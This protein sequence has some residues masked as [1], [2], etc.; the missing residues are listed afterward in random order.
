MGEGRSGGF[1]RPTFFAI[2]LVLGVLVVAQSVTHLVVVLGL[3]RVGTFVDLDRSNGLP[4]I[5]STLA[6]ALAAVGAGL[7][8]GRGRGPQR[9]AGIGLTAVLACLTLADLLHDGAHPSSRTGPYVI[10]LVLIAGLLLLVVAGASGTRARLTFA[11]AALVL[12]ASFFGEG[13]DRLDHWFERERGDP[14][15]EAQIVAKE[16]LELLGWS[17]VALGLWDEALRRRAATPARARASRA[18]AASRRRAA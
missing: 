5:L 17:L 12:A 16:G 13:L 6:L 4:D 18:Q 11:V 9:A 14:V 3:D 15:A 2:V 1:G 7:V 8:A 10:A